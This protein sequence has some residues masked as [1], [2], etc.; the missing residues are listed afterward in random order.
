MKQA[1]LTTA[2]ILTLAGT[3]AAQAGGGSNAAETSAAQHAQPGIVAAIGCVHAGA[4][5]S[6]GEARAEGAQGATYMLT[7]AGLGG[8]T[9]AAGAPPAPAT[10]SLEGYDLSPYIGHTV[11]VIATTGGAASTGAAA[12]SLLRVTSAVRLG[13][14][15]SSQTSR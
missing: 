4:S 11:Q 3:A 10:Y 15:C 9:A 7:N 5:A 1:V 12:N 6:E 2:I 14:G 13:T 8:S